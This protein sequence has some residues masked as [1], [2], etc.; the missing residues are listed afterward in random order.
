MIKVQSSIF[1]FLLFAAPFVLGSKTWSLD[2]V[3][4]QALKVSLESQ[5]IQEKTKSDSLIKIKALEPYDW[6]FK[7]KSPPLNKDIYKPFFKNSF[8]AL[9]KK[10][11][12]GF[13]SSI[14]YPSSE[15]AFISPQ[16][17]LTENKFI[18]NLEQNL[19]RNFFGRSD[20][21]LLDSANYKYEERSFLRKK[22]MRQIVHK[23]AEL[24]WK[25]LLIE[26][27]LK[28]IKTAAKDYKELASAARQK[29][30]LGHS[31]PGEIPQILS[32]YENYLN[33]QNTLSNQLQNFKKG[34]KV[35]LQTERSNFTF[36]NKKLPGLPKNKNIKDTN[37]LDLLKEVEA[38]FKAV[39]SQT[40]AQKYFYLPYLKLTAQAGF[41]EKKDFSNMMKS[42]SDFK[43]MYIGFELIYPFPR[44]K[45]HS[46]LLAQEEEARLQYESSKQSLSHQLDSSWL[47]VKTYRKSML[48]SKKIL[49]LQK[50]ALK[51][52][53]QAY[54]Q[55]RTP[56]DF[57]ISAQK[58]FISSYLENISAQKQYSLSW[59]KYH[60]LR[61]Q[62]L[63]RYLKE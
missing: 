26:T 38:R 12:Y 6:Q 5:I 32:E 29:E 43:N 34:L 28:Q 49:N 45:K 37:S 33:Q 9:Q 31:K 56:I 4:R 25:G 48:A 11:A 40:Q 47:D 62:L 24:F 51:E 44:W 60:S 20:R 35:F 2:Q 59:I 41:S 7:M 58:R 14:L 21:L 57:L 50:K 30:Q 52:I 61:N 54:L 19:L 10:W 15:L 36:Q 22:E 16:S 8:Y 46:S 17:A 53:R 13:T 3:I 55:G 23:A 63:E 42:P 39:A 18:L 1:L 27:H